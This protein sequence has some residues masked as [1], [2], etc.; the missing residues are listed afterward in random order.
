MKKPSTN[1]ISNCEQ[2][3][4]NYIDELPK[5]IEVH[6]Y[7]DCGTCECPSGDACFDM[8]KGS[9]R[10]YLTFENCVCKD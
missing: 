10:F 5:Y 8:L 4:Q 9:Y 6:V 7:G 1:V 3:R 2:Q